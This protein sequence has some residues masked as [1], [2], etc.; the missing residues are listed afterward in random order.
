MLKRYR[1]AAVGL[2]ALLVTGSLAQAAGSF[3]TLPIVGGASYCA[4]TVSGTGA[5]SGIT[6]QGQGTTGSICAQTVPAGPS[7]LTGNEVIP[8]DLFTPG[9]TQAITGASPATA[10]IPIVAFGNGYGGTVINTTTG[11]QTPVVANGISTYIYAGAGAATF[12][13]FTFP[14]NPMQNQKLC[15]VDAGTGIVTLSSLL[16]GTAGQVFAG[17]TPTSLPVQTAVG[18]AGTV[19]LGTNC[20]LYNVANTTWYRVL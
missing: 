11:A 16:V 4:T 6:G 3:S 18:T 9:T 20:W 19:T 7:A 8:A 5:L 10:D 13:T 15:L 14:P 1:G 17:V 12:T 2:C